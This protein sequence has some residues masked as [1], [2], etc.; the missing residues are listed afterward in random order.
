MP[1]TRTLLLLLLAT[2]GL[3]LPSGAPKCRITDTTIMQGHAVTMSNQGF[4]LSAPVRIFLSYLSLAL[5]CLLLFACLSIGSGS[6]TDNCRSPQATYT[7]GGAAMT[8]TVNNAQATAFMGI[9]AYVS[10]GS[11]QDS[12]LTAMGLTANPPAHVGAFQNLAAM[13]LRAQTTAS[14]AAQNVT[15]EA[16]E[17]TITHNAPL[18]ATTPYSLTWTP[19]AADQGTVTV[20]MVI[21][22]GT[23]GTPYQILT[24]VQIASSAG[25][26]AAGTTSSAGAV[27][28]AATSSA[29]AATSAAVAATSAAVTT[30]SSAATSAATS[31]AITT[32]SVATTAAAN[33]ITTATITVANS[34]SVV[35][36]TA[37]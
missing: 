14:C 34:I 27:N 31:A 1:A 19:P 15:N 33:G 29:V 2:V 10:V 8:I 9:L 20:N 30:K 25:T 37:T 18:Q 36:V 28:V 26:A 22:I 23:K 12:T 35:V 13:G 6:D 5:A 16:A 11:T 17:S 21:S 7:P 3:A 24:S 4:T 32:K